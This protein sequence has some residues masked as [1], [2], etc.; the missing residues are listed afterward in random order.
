M[1]FGQFAADVPELLEVVH[2]GVLGPLDAERG[3][4]ARA[5]AAFD[6]VGLLDLLRQREEGLGERFGARDQVGR[7]AVIAD[8]GKAVLAER[9]AEFVGDFVQGAGDRYGGDFGHRER[10]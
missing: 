2:R 9:P 1:A 5:A 7:D 3:V 8:D 4:A 10:L 6:L